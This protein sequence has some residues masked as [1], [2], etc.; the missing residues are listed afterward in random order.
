MIKDIDKQ[1][2]TILAYYPETSVVK[3][4]MS[5]SLMSGG[6]RLRPQLLLAMLQDFGCDYQIG[7]YPACALEMVHTY[8]LVH[9]DLPAMDDDDMRRFKPTNHKV[10]G[11]GVAI[12]AGDAL[13]TG[14]FTALSQASL[15]ADVLGK[16]FEIL[17][18][19]AG[20]NGMI[21]GQEL[22]ID[23]QIQHIDDLVACYNLKTGCLFAAAF[24]M[25]AVIAG[26]DAYQKLA[27]EL[28]LSLGVA[29]QFQDDLLEVTKSSEEIG[30]SNQSDA[31][32]DK[33][34]VV[35]LLG[36]EQA[37][38]LTESYFSSIKDLLRKMNIENGNLKQIIDEMMSREL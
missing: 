17:A 24:E 27:H 5:Y 7:L 30:K 35:S 21:L 33:T 1:L 25:A 37:R 34:T 16:C 13:L 11:E 6:K 19:N 22:D 29:F 28:G 18:R 15:D 23:D 8:S 9:D 20:S 32:R 14:A 4:A 36:L 38:T 31:E 26:Q 3:E 2:L 10:F 12:L